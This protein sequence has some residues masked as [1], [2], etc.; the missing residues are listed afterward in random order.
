MTSDG[1]LR[2]VERCRLDHGDRE[3]MHGWLA[4]QPAGTPVAI[5]AAFG[6]P[7]IA[8]LLDQFDLEPHLAHP[9]AVRVLAKHR[10]KSDRCDADR[11]GEFLLCGIL[12]E[13]YLAPPAVR[14]L[15]ERMRYRMALSRIRTGIKNRIQ[16]ALHRR[17]V[18]H[19]YSDLFGKAGRE[20]LDTLGLPEATGLVLAGYLELLDK[21]NELIDKVERWMN[22][23][24]KEDET[25]RLLQ[26]LPGVGVILAH[27]LRA[28]IGELERFPDSRHLCSYA[29]LAPI[30][31]D[32][33][34]RHGRR[35]TSPACNRTLRWAFVEAA[36]V[37]VATGARRADRL[38]H[39]YHRLTHG[40]RSNK[41]QAKVALARELAKLAYVVWQKREP[42][43]EHP[44][45]RPGSQRPRK[46][47]NK[48]KNPKRT[49]RPDQPRH[50]MVRRAPAGA[51]QTLK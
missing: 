21:V 7:W 46:T 23:H 48:S 2:I 28:E 31:D 16:A 32:S 3:Q 24:I 5:E 29:G 17:G 12:P 9:P 15:R 6:W 49:V 36:N 37:I 19:N 42:Y 1:Q 10:A 51:G 20:F 18:L 11:L 40:G 50:P 43:T 44:P 8:D 14:Q 4:G 45:P 35:H 30:S 38:L 25:T 27:V 33:A 34:D 41:S 13:S 47:K 26:T 22:R 39:L